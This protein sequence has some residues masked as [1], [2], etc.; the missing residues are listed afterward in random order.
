MREPFTLSIAFTSGLSY[1]REASPWN[2]YRSPS[3][4]ITSTKFRC[5]YR[6]SIY[7]ETIANSFF[8]PDAGRNFSRGFPT[9]FP[10]EMSR[11]PCVSDSSSS[12]VLTWTAVPFQHAV[13]SKATSSSFLLFLR[14]PS[15]PSLFQ[16]IHPFLR[17][18]RLLFM[19]L[20]S[21]SSLP[22]HP[23]VSFLAFIIGGGRFSSF[24]FSISRR[25]RFSCSFPLRQYWGSVDE[26]RRKKTKVPQFCRQ[27]ITS[28]NRK[29]IGRTG[30]KGCGTNLAITC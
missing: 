15:P 24:Y 4:F 12:I 13:S 26:R 5:V 1:S 10:G 19:L 23:Q 28:R 22:C 9:I 6:S 17:L 2:W 11:L 21:S 20:P 7:D 16:T 27:Y 30:K 3:A 25:M 8:N 18:S 29:R 14:P